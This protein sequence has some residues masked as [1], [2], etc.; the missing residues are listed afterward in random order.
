MVTNGSFIRFAAQYALHPGAR[1]RAWISFTF[2]SRAIFAITPAFSQICIGFFVARL[3][4]RISSPPTRPSS[5]SS[6]PPT[7]ATIG[8]APAAFSASA[9]S[10]VV[11]SAPPAPRCG[12]T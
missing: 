2:R 1:L 5:P 9:T 11:R 6:R 7:L 10:I 8:I 12:M 4:M 3:S